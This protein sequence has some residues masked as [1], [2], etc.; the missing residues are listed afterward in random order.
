ML[1]RPEA[2]PLALAA[3]AALMLAACDASSPSAPLDPRGAHVAPAVVFHE[4]IPLQVP[5]FNTCTGR[6][7]VIT[8]TFQI[9]VTETT[10]ANGGLHTRFVSNFQNVSG[11][12]LVTGVRYRVISSLEGSFNTNGT[13]QRE[14]TT[15]AIMKLVGQGPFNNTTVRMNAHLTLNAN[16]TVTAEFSER[17]TSSCT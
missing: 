8:G 10:D 15:L 14:S 2:A 1:S 3:V 9:L 17:E 5:F 13:G 4:F 16:G 6:S 7:L 11:V 12:D